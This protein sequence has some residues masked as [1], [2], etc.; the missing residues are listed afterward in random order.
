MYLP[1]S[2]HLDLA[3][4]VSKVRITV[5]PQNLTLDLEYSEYSLVYQLHSLVV[6]LEK[7]NA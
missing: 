4:K 2:T 1:V 7:I 3:C 5:S 6:L